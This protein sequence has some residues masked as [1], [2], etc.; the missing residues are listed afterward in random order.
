LIAPIAAVSL[1]LLAQEERWG[2][3]NAVAVPPWL[4]VLLGVIAIDLGKYV[5]HRLY[6]AV[7]ILWRVHQIHHSDLDVDCGTALRHHPGET[8]LTQ[9]FDLALI[10]AVGVPPLGVVAG[11]TLSGVASLFTHAN[12]AIPPAVDGVLRSLFVT[13][14]MHR[15]HHSVDVGESNRNFANLFACWD[16]LFSTYA[17]EP[18]AGHAQMVVGL[19]Y[20]RADRDPSLWKLLAL[21]FRPVRADPYDKDAP[22]A[23]RGGRLTY[24]SRGGG[25]CDS[26]APELADRTSAHIDK[27]RRPDELRIDS[28]N[29][30]AGARIDFRCG[31]GSPAAGARSTGIAGDQCGSRDRDRDTQAPEVTGDE[32]SVH[33][34]LANLNQGGAMNIRSIV[35][36]AL[37]SLAWIPAAAGGP[38]QLPEPGV[39]A[40]IGVGAVAG[41]AVAIRNRRKK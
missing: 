29:R 25:G 15:I 17:R 35:A 13:P 22:R 9:A 24:R 10:V 5:Q 32:R 26:Q 21:P 37:L 1:A 40:L 27:L 2:L 14:D 8:V 36:I 7:P 20:I 11:F 31:R 41:I 18:A 38:A 39:L 30:A 34:T 12:V 19:G 4:S 6:H 16:R 33:S 23:D 3:L 28:R